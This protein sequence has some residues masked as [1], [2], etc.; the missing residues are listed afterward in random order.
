MHGLSCIRV[1]VDVRPSEG[2]FKLIL[3]PPD[4]TR[5]DLVW[6]T[7]G[8]CSDPTTPEMARFGFAIVVVSRAGG[9]VAYGAGVPPDCVTDSGMA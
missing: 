6:Y 2:T 4:I 3:E 7:D 1:P 9:L 8:S 5:N